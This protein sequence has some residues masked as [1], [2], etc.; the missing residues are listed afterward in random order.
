MVNVLFTAP[1]RQS[2]SP[3]TGNRLTNGVR[4]GQ[5]RRP[6]SGHTDTSPASLIAIC[7]G[8]GAHAGWVALAGLAGPRGTAQQGRGCANQ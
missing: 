8:A 4:P 1:K 5:N 7:R 6:A 2:S 3:L